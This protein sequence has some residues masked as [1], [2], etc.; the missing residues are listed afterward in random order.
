MPPKA[1]LSDPVVCHCLQVTESTIVD[2]VTLFG[3]SSV[4][5]VKESCGAGGGCMACRRRIQC[6]IQSRG[7]ETRRLP[8]G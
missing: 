4:R 6:L 7:S 8:Q 2:C 3:A 1:T 5:D